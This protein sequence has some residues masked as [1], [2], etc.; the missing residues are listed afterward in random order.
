M[1]QD[2]IQ[3][4]NPGVL[5]KMHDECLF[6]CA[7]P[8]D[9]AMQANVKKALEQISTITNRFYQNGNTAKQQAMMASGIANTELFCSYSS[10]IARWLVQ[11]FPGSV[12]LGGSDAP[13]ETVRNILQALLPVVE[14]EKSSQGE[15][16]LPARI[17]FISG[18][19]HP[20]AQLNWLL[21]LFNDSHLPELVKEELYNQ[22]KVFVRWK[23]DNGNYSR[24]FLEW[25]VK[26]GFYQSDFIKQVNTAELVKQKLSAPVQ[27]KPAEKTALLDTMKASLAFLYRETDPVTYG[28]INELELFD[29]GRGLQIALIGMKKERR[30]ALETYIGFMAF[31]NGIPVS[32]GGGWMWGNRCKIGVNIYPAFRKGESAWLFCQVMRL[33]YQH[34]GMRYFSVKPYQ[35]GKGNPEGIKSGAFWFY[36]K[37]GFRSANKSI[38]ETAAAEWNKI[39]ADKKY[40][41]PAK[42]LQQFTKA[43]LEIKLGN[44]IFPSNDAG[45]VSAAI[46]KYI[47]NQFNGNRKEAILESFKTLENNFNLSKLNYHSVY[48]QKVIENWSLLFSAFNNTAKWKLN[49][50]NAFTSLIKLKQS[51]SERAYILTAQENKT[52]WKLIDDITD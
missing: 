21:Q 40:R 25:P 33:Y 16:T 44:S 32:Y 15:G 36:Y 37:L 13:V 5:K 38:N 30:L 48:L 39:A 18:L 23:L 49:D 26:T 17:K 45:Q 4:N 2:N 27:L 24:T 51:G 29:M 20:G 43:P 12:E 52:F 34:Y 31:K 3:P 9:K 46:S 19:R 14:Y 50:K 11:K 10:T 47:N 6:Q 28:D 22:L 1:S 7:F 42:L 35:F 41:T 8:S